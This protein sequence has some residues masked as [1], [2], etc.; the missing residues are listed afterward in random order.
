MKRNK[1]KLLKKISKSFD[2]IHKDLVLITNCDI[3]I[4]QILGDAYN[5]I[6]DILDDDSLDTRD[7]LDISINER[8][9]HKKD[10]EEESENYDYY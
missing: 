9:Q 7:D 6:Y 3:I 4:E 5:N 8:E 1:L 10:I 2:L